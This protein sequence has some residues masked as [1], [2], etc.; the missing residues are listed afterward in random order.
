MSIVGDDE[1]GTILP[2]TTATVEEGDSALDVLKRITRQHKIQM[3]YRGAKA[4]GYVEGIANLYEMDRGAESGWMYRVNGKFPSESAGAYKLKP[5]DTVEWLY[6]LDMG[7][8]L[9]ASR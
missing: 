9:G 4:A 3:E 8:D 7:K 5:G 6:T 1:L 2:P